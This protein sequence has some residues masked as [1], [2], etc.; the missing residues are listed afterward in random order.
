MRILHC[1]RAPVGGLFRHVVDLA[2]QQVADGHEVGVLADAS[3]GGPAA[4]ATF[5]ALAPILALGITRVRMPRQLGL[6]DY[7]AL[8]A[9]QKLAKDLKIDVLHGHGAKGGAYARLAA[10]RLKRFGHAVKAFYTPHGGSLHFEPG[11]LQGTLFLGLEQHLAT[12]SDGIIFESAFSQRA[13][14]HKVGIP[15]CPERVIPNGLLPADFVEVTPAPGARDVLFVGELRQLKGVD[16]LLEA[17]AQIETPHAPTAMIV[18]GGPDADTFKARAAELGL[19]DRVAFPGPMPAPKA[20]PLG[21]CIVVPSRAESFPYIVLEAAAAGLPMLMTGV[22]GIPEITAGLDV[23]FLIPGDS[24]SLARQ[25]QLFLTNPAA[26]TAQAKALR[27]RVA[28]RYTVAN[29]ASEIQDFYGVP[30]LSTPRGAANERQILT[31]G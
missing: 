27:T 15:P 10:T 2:R 13:Y 12:Q 23:P 5:A 28:G 8:M 22:G 24:S 29:M 14:R 21:R 9:T 18:G 4:E 3:T 30:A 26:Q 17:L 19:G 31:S 25:L 6:G 11:T 7:T 20:F 1:L 16:V